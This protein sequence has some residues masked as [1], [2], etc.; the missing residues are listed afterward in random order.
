MNATRLW[1]IG[2]ALAIV[3]ILAGGWFLGAQPFIAQAKA[4][5]LEQESVAQVNAAQRA[6]IDQLAKAQ[7]NLPELEAELA[8]LTDYLPE[9]ASMSRLVGELAQIAFG[10]GVD[11]TT[12]TAAEATLLSDAEGAPA[13]AP[14]ETAEDGE[15]TTKSAATTAVPEVPGMVAIPIQLS[16]DGSLDA[17][18]AFV[19]SI[20][21]LDRLITV[22]GL[23]FSENRDKGGF[24]L[25]LSGAVYVQPTA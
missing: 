16:A 14:A 17:L 12:V 22:S 2:G 20:Q 19:S 25:N 21:Q 1:L 8:V 6:R 13:P 15:A 24:S 5:N 7:E 4:A 10:S 23:T 18:Q 3:A 9:N 11:I